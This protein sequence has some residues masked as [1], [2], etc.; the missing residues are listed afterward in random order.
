MP[1][2][3]VNGTPL[4]TV[5]DR[6]CTSMPAASIS[7]SR[8]EPRSES[9]ASRREPRWVEASPLRLMASAN[10]AARKC[11]STAIVRTRGLSYCISLAQHDFR[12]LD[13]DSN[14]V[15]NFQVEAF[16]RPAGDSRDHFLAAGQ[17]YHHLS[18]DSAKCHTLDR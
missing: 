3:P 16:G 4:P 5:C 13:D 7:A 18:H 10:P 9:C 15:S 2:A 1:S 14:L 11:S 17:L 8:S 6:T 12:R